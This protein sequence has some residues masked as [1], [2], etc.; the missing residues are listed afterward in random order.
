MTKK[1]LSSTEDVKKPGAKN[2]AGKLLYHLVD[3]DAHEALVSVLTLGAHKYS[4]GGWRH[5]EDA[6]DRYD[7]ALMRHRRELRRFIKCIKG[8][9][10]VAEVN[11]YRI[12]QE[13]GLPHAA[14]LQ[15]NAHFIAALDI[16][17]FD[18]TF[19]GTEAAR[20]AIRRWEAVKASKTK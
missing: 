7:D 20:E 10:P 3:D 1:T 13:T 8:G 9:R 14:Q 12:D 19:D 16:F 4:P 5:V 6:F 2:D 15:C 17:H 11:Q 18:P